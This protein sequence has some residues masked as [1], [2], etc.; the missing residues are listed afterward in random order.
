MV[1]GLPVTRSPC[2]VVKRLYALM[3]A[4][5]LLVHAFPLFSDD[6]PPSRSRTRLCAVISTAHAVTGHAFGELD[7]GSILNKKLG[8][9]SCAALPQHLWSCFPGQVS[10]Y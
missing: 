7:S 6:R 1:A 4:V 2:G 8:G 3:N 10:I 5:C 9:Q